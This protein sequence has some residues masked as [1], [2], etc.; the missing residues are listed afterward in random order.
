MPQVRQPDGP[1]WASGVD[2]DATY[3]LLEELDRIGGLI[4]YSARAAGILSEIRYESFVYLAKRLVKESRK[5]PPSSYAAMRISRDVDTVFWVGMVLG[6]LIPDVAD[7]AF[8]ATTLAGAR[9]PVIFR[10]SKV[11]KEVRIPARDDLFNRIEELAIHEEDPRA[12]VLHAKVLGQRE[13]Y[14]E[15]L[16]VL[17]TVMPLI[18]PT[19]MRPPVREDITMGDTIDPPWKVYAWL[20]EKLGDQKATDQALKMA[21]LVYQDPGALITY[22]HVMQQEGNMEMYEECMSKA[23]TSGDPE[24]CRKL[25]NF[26]YLTYR[27]RFPMRDGDEAEV[28]DKDKSQ[29]QKKKI[30][31]LRSKIAALFGQ[32]RTRQDY[33]KLAIDWYELAFNHGSRKAAIILSMLLREDGDSEAG[34]HFLELAEQEPKLVPLT[35]RL[36]ENW[37]NK[38]FE[39]KIPIQLLDT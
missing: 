1:S 10:A 12:I 30:G 19:K 26:Y 13:Q 18:Y 24:A 23:A 4:Y 14:Q 39:F 34:K 3:L 21:A 22:A 35:R 36:R 28:K 25:A 20:K 17:E 9:E 11:L 5:G 2:S 16:A 38:E 6:P 37:N 15:A 31:F 27:G 33:R 29:H 8:V 32:T 7:W